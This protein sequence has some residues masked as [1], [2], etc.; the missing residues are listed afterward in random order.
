MVRAGPEAASTTAAAL[1]QN[2]RLLGHAPVGR[3]S[4]F[5][6]AV[7]PGHAAAISLHSERKMKLQ[8]MNFVVTWKM[9]TV[10]AMIPSELAANKWRHAMESRLMDF[11]AVESDA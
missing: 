9:Q 1:V 4:F 5:L 6:A 8:S 11:G 10:F 7:T 2:L 3:C